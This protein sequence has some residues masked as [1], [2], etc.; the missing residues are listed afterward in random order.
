MWSLIIN[1][2]VG[3]RKEDSSYEYL[4]SL[5]IECV[6]LSGV[7]WKHGPILHGPE[8][9]ASTHRDAVPPDPSSG[10]AHTHRHTP[11]AA[12]VHEQVCLIHERHGLR[13]ALCTTILKSNTLFEILP[14]ICSFCIYKIKQI[15]IFDVKQEDWET[16]TKDLMIW[17]SAK[18]AKKKEE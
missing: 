8:P 2:L 10:M 7:L 16:L 1:H 11:G 14:Y 5:L 6:H 3:C 12:H 15:T 4:M 13:T 9:A 18:F 17:N